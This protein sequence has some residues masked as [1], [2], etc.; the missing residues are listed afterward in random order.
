MVLLCGCQLTINLDVKYHVNIGA[1][2]SSPNFYFP[3][4]IVCNTVNFIK[5]YTEVF[6]LFCNCL[7][8]KVSHWFPV[9]FY[10]LGDLY[11]KLMWCVPIL[12]FYLGNNPI[13]TAQSLLNPPS[14]G[15]STTYLICHGIWSQFNWVILFKALYWNPI[16][17]FVLPFH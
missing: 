11:P 13:L 10:C 16:N 6:Y 2:I 5:C 14:E 3:H 17:W 9:K 15:I 8:P 1:L 12:G 4:L 7:G